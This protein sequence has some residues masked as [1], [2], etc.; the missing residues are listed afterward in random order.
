[1]RIACAQGKLIE[2]LRIVTKSGMLSVDLSEDGI[3]LYIR[4]M[5]AFYA[6]LKLYLC[7]VNSKKNVVISGALGQLN[8]L[9][10]LLVKNKVHC[11][12]LPANVGY[13]S[14]QME[15]IK[16]NYISSIDE[17]SVHPD[18]GKSAPPLLVSATK[19]RWVDTQTL[20][21]PEYWAEN[22]IHPVRFLNA[23]SKVCSP[24]ES[25]KMVARGYP[26]LPEVN[27][28][29]EIGPHSSL[30]QHTA[31]ILRDTGKVES[32]SYLSMLTRDVSSIQ[33]TLEVAGHLHC[34]GYPI[35]LGIVN[36]DISDEKMP[37]ILS[38]LPGYPFDHST[39]YWRESR[40]SQNC[41]RNGW[42]RHPLLGVRDPYDNLTE[43]RWRNVLR[44]AEV[45]WIEDHKVGQA[46][47]CQGVV[48]NHTHQIN[49]SVLYPAA[50]MLAMAIEATKHAASPEDEMTGFSIR[51]AVFYSALRIPPG[52]EGVEVDITLQQRT[53]T[54]KVN[55]LW[56]DFRI[57]S[58]EGESPVERC[59]G[60]VEAIFNLDKI[61]L[62]NCQGVESRRDTYTRAA[63]YCIFGIDRAQFYYRLA[64]Y[65]YNYGPVFQPISSLKYDGTDDMEIISEVLVLQGHGSDVAQLTIHPTTLDGVLQMMTAIYTDIG[66][67]AKPPALPSRID[68]LWLSS[69]GF[70][71]PGSG[72]VKV[73][74]AS[75]ASPNGEVAY[76][77][78]VLDSNQEKTVMTIDG[79]QATA[80]ES[81]VQHVQDTPAKESLCHHL[82]WKPDVDLLSSTDLRRGW[83]DQEVHHEGP[84]QLDRDL[85]FLLTIYVLKGLDYMQYI[86][87]ACIKQNLGHYVDWIIGQK[88]RLEAGKSRCTLNECRDAMADD[89]VI[90]ELHRRVECASKGGLFFSSICRSLIGVLEEEITPRGLLE[91]R[92]VTDYCRE[93]VCTAFH[94]R[95]G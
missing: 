88:G 25:N 74:A 40:I 43:P 79:L 28:V 8:S 63:Q 4:R 59:T 38:D 93:M 53:D 19:S 65:G 81:A 85:D 6:Q 87:R 2:D 31:D 45:S 89:N 15:D 36:D 1:M 22:L 71:D 37:K 68:R 82:V 29:L 72:C 86:D 76:T 42:D 7:A 90:D 3:R 21:N 73:H 11:R 47:V 61:G 24:A 32:I 26:P 35:N 50:A 57:R 44:R 34:S 14:G 12:F 95:C 94:A 27:H 51:D 77:M 41:R 48:A 60:S 75:E 10:Q 83:N 18:Y 91:G 54:K 5:S 16:A 78:V 56:F 80:T 69:T 52:S 23:M 62:E 55:T 13:H 70:N 92:L 58:Y 66:T 49:G 17:L 33:T 39:S 64:E 67:E 9:E 30:K 84:A 20:L 46:T